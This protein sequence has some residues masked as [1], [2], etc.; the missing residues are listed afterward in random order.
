MRTL[1]ETQRRLQAGEV[2]S[3]DLI[4]ESLAAIAAPEGEGRRAFLTVYAERARREADAVDAARGEGRPLPP[5]AGVPLGV[6]DLFDVAGEVTRAG[7]HVLDGEPPAKSDADAVAEIRRA[8]FIVVGKNNMTE[9]AYSGL[10]VNTAFSTPLSPYDRAS[11]R[12]PGGS[13]S[14]GAVAVA[15]GMVP[16]VLGTDTGG[17][18][19]IPAAFCGIVGFKPTSAR[20]SR[21]GAFALS[22]T[23]DSIGP[24]A[25]SVACCAA[26]DAV[27]V[28]GFGEI[29]APLPAYGLRIGVVE[30]FVDEDL[31]APVAAAYEAALKRLAQRGVRLE[32]VRI[33]E[34]V[35]YVTAIAKG[36]FVGAEAYALHRRWLE[37]RGELYDPFVR[38]RL[39]TGYKQTAA[40]YIDLLHARKRI[41]AAVQ[42]RT[43][44]FDA[45][46]LPTVPII[47]PLIAPLADMDTAMAV[48]RRCLR[49]TAIGNFLD[50]PSISIPCHAPGSA[51]VGFMLTGEPLGDRRLFAIAQGL[52]A[53]I[54]GN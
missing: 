42:A 39:E 51:P 49:N 43:H 32:K 34:F 41:C 9:F 48:N 14:G 44:M 8:G 40:D 47:P 16:A 10:G 52:E 28:G 13:T 21:R 54:R 50:R 30:G 38:M 17:S 22:E 36:G 46:A 37:T 1:I 19:R 23:L 31:D 45:L 20:V 11:G 18:C 25:N 33:P 3:R 4:E 27:L 29:E 6:K 15:D 12:I 53:T 2:G 7:S 24:L 5:F 35:D 26:L